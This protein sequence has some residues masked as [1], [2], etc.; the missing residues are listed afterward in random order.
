[1]TKRIF[2]KDER[3]RPIVTIVKVRGETPTVIEVSGRRYVMEHRDTWR[4]KRK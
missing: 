3:Y 1:M 4:G 2:V